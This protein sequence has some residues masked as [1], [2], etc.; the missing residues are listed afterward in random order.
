MERNR[1][2]KCKSL[3][4]KNLSSG[5]NIHILEERRENFPTVLTTNTVRLLGLKSKHGG[6]NGFSH[7]IQ[8]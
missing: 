8:F 6:L 3:E 7:K 5:I 2:K 4:N 1:L